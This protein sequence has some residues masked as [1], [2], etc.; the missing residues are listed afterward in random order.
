MMPN[1]NATWADAKKAFKFQ[2][3]IG[4]LRGGRYMGLTEKEI[5]AKP[6]KELILERKPGFKNSDNYL[7][8]PLYIA[9]SPDENGID[10]VRGLIS[11]DKVDIFFSVN[12]KWNSS[13]CQAFPAKILEADVCRVPDSRR[14][15]TVSSHKMTAMFGQDELAQLTLAELKEKPGPHDKTLNS[16]QSVAKLLATVKPQ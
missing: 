3:S 10:R 6:S 5:M 13:T 2:K 15:N 9:Y 14:R 12:G 8:R 7:S 4:N 1:P 16:V 11:C